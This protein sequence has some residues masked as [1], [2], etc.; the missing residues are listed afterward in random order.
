MALF[1]NPT[2]LIL[3]ITLNTDQ[4]P[5]T[6]GHENLY[7]NSEPIRNNRQVL[8]NDSREILLMRNTQSLKITLQQGLLCLNHFFLLRQRPELTCFLINVVG[9][10]AS[11]SSHGVPDISQREHLFMNVM[12]HC[13][14]QRLLQWFD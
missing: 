14:C 11:S 4:L 10:S 2:C 1:N 12:L 13:C 8:F 3:G 5:E 9:T 6:T 7:Q